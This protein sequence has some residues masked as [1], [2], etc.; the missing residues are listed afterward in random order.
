VAIVLS[1]LLPLAIVLSVLLPLAI[2]LS[3]LL[4]VAIV[5][6]VLLPLAIVLSFLL[7]FTASVYSFG[8]FKIV[9]SN[10]V[11]SSTPRHLRDWN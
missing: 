1:V 9:L 5:L 2:V 3:V 4:P 6:S 11:V 8:F 10:N 7:R